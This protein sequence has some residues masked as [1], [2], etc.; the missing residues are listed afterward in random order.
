MIG[1]L[2]FDDGSD[3]VGKYRASLNELL[4]FKDGELVDRLTAVTKAEIAAK[5][6]SLIGG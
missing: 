4:F 5:L 2:D 1:K 6:D 3:I